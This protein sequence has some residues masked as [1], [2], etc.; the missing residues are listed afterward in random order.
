MQQNTSLI[1]TVYHFSN[2]FG[3][4]LPTF[5]HL[6][7]KMIDHNVKSLMLFFDLSTSKMRFWGNA[8]CVFP[9][10][11]SLIKRSNFL[12]WISSKDNTI[13]IYAKKSHVAGISNTNSDG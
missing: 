2:K 1:F 6:K 4:W 5:L 9:N 12:S 13:I 8:Q 7:Q 11:L 3:W 10:L